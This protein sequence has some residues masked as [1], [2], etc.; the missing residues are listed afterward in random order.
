MRNVQHLEQSIKHLFPELLLGNTLD[1]LA[2]RLH[3]ERQL[4]GL[5]DRQRGQMDVV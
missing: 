1:Q 2:G 3:L 5:L 4:E